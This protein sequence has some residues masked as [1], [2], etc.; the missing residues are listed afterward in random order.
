M[1]GISSYHGYN[2][3]EKCQNKRDAN[4]FEMVKGVHLEIDEDK[5]KIKVY[6]YK[7][8]GKAPPE[9]FYYNSRER[10]I[11][12]IKN[13][14]QI[15][16]NDGINNNNLVERPKSVASDE[17]PPSAPGPDSKARSQCIECLH[18]IIEELGNHLRHLAIYVF[19][20]GIIMSVLVGFIKIQYAFISL[21]SATGLFTG[22]T[23]SEALVNGAE[24]EV[25]A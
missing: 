6:D 23:I 18:P 15:D 5:D 21:A 7:E 4:Y 2:I 3:A 11:S 25:K 20:G 9:V 8:R 17:F 13:N 14:W 19:L 24:R 16:C 10:R 22:F 12:E 1:I